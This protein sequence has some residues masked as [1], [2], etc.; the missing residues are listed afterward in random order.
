MS[1]DDDAKKGQSHD[2]TASSTEDSAAIFKLNVAM[3]DALDAKVVDIGCHVNNHQA[4][5][6]RLESSRENNHGRTFA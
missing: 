4:V 1:T 6:E 5:L 2:E 3:V